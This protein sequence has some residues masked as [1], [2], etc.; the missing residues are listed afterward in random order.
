MPQA[1]SPEHHLPGNV[2]FSSK[3]QPQN[4]YLI[5]ELDQSALSY[6]NYTIKPLMTIL[7]QQF[8]INHSCFCVRPGQKPFRHF[9]KIGKYD[10]SRL[11]KKPA[12]CLYRCENKDADQIF[13]SC[14]MVIL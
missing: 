3:Q 1:S 9:S 5:A 14:K 12:F 2:V 11:I 7:K 13:N 4:K 10:M 8:R 6:P